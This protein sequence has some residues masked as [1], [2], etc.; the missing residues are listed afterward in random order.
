MNFVYPTRE[1]AVDLNRR[2]KTCLLFLMN[3]VSTLIDSKTDLAK[4][5][6]MVENGP[7]RMAFL[8][9]DSIRILNEIRQTIPEK[10]RA[11]LMAT[12]TDYEMRLV[13]KATP[14]KT[15]VVLQ[16]E[17][18]RTLIDAAQ[19]KCMDCTDTFEESAK[20]NLCKL[21]K[22]HLPMDTY[23]GTY[24]CPYNGREWGN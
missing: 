12:A 4:R 8:A 5:L 13:P 22:T 15:S 24:L 3:T 14:S 16:K 20:C 10:Q 7:E 17:E 18:L 11:N 23:E 9:D 2:E 6:E 21:L 1:D 19:I